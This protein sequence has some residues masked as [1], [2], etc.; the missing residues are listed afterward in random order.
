M[1]AEFSISILARE[2]PLNGS[3]LRIALSLPSGNLTLQFK[4]VGNA[5][6]QALAAQ[7][8]NLDLCHIQPTRMFG[9][10]VKAHAAQQLASSAPTSTSSKDFREV[11]VQVVQNFLCVSPTNI[12]YA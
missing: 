4:W 12:S 6:V 9:R 11:G 1:S 10:A 7:D 3:M 2:R 8:A 5:P